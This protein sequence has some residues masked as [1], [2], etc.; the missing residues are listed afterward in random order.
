MSRLKDISK[1]VL[2][3]LKDTLICARSEK[4]ATSVR[5]LPARHQSGASRDRD[6]KAK[7][8]AGSNCSSVIRIVFP[9]G[10]L[11]S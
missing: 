8:E 4:V 7:T 6:V 5:H 1:E 2:E 3:L 9:D 11:I 10:V